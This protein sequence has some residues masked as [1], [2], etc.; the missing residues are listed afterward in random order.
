MNSGDFYPNT[1]TLKNK[2]GIRDNNKLQRFEQYSV[3]DR[4]IEL[5][6]SP[7]QGNFNQ[8][9]FEKTH[10]MLF[11]DVYAFAGKEQKKSSTGNLKNAFNNLAA[12][13]FL[14][15]LRKDEF[16]NKFSSYYDELSKSDHFTKGNKRT[17]DVFMSQ[18]AKQ[19]GYEVD[20]TKL[21]QEKLN[22]SIYRDKPKK[23]ENTKPLTPQDINRNN[24]LKSLAHKLLE[25]GAS[26]AIFKSSIER[27]NH[28]LKA[29]AK[30][31]TQGQQD[32]GNDDLER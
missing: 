28:V 2:E 5:M 22:N 30:A 4:T 32:K 16:I 23:Q 31:P 9:H 12:D 29:S 13:N 21:K 1:T 27:A 26:N 24:V 14:K 18:L 15:S 6:Q 10:K 8:E 11:K 20:F 19:A 7:L 3:N 17:T 25:T